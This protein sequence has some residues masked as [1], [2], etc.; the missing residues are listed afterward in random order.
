[1]PSAVHKV[2]ASPFGRSDTIATLNLWFDIIDQLKVMGTELVNDF[3]GYYKGST[4]EAGVLFQ[5][6][7]EKW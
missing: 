5:Y 3:E 1:M 6:I 2:L 4:K 7:N